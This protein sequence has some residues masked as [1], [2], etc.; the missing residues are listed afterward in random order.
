VTFRILWFIVAVAAILVLGFAGIGHAFN[1]ILDI[2][3]EL[4]WTLG[5]EAEVG[6]AYK[7]AGAGPI[8]NGQRGDS[9]MFG[10]Y[11][12]RFLKESYGII[13]DPQNGER[14]GDGLKTGLKLNYFLGW[15][16]SPE[17]PA[18]I[19]LNKINIGPVYTVP[20]LSTTKPFQGGTLWVEA[21][22]QFGN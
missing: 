15:F 13:S 8:P 7:I 12:Y 20:I 18:M 1:P 9:V 5:E 4:K 2:Q 10:I 3:T 6:T 14:F 11:D 21:N 17:T 22:L 19:F 16:K